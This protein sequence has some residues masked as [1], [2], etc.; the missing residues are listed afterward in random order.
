MP[1]G[2]CHSNLKYRAL[3]R[4]FTS[5]SSGAAALKAVVAAVAVTLSV[6]A[7]VFTFWALTRVE[8]WLAERRYADAYQNEV[9]AEGGGG[10][11]LVDDGAA[12]PVA[13]TSVYDEGLEIVGDEHELAAQALSHAPS[14]APRRRPSTL[15]TPTT[16]PRV[17]FPPAVPYMIDNGSP[18]VRYFAITFDGGSIAN[19]AGEILD[20]LASRGVKSTMFLTGAFI[21][22]FPNVV[23][24]I[25]GEGHEL[26]N[27]TLTHPRLTTYADNMTQST[28]PGIS[29]QTIANELNGAARVLADRTG[30]R[31]APLWRAPYGEY[32]P[33]ICR[34]AVDAGYVH[35]G[36]RHGRTWAQNLDTNDWVPDESHAAYRT[37]GEVYDKIVNIASGPQG[38]NGGIIL[39]HL[40]TERKIRSEQAHIILGRLIDTLR[41][42]GYEPV[43]V[44]ELLYRSGIDVNTLAFG[45]RGTGAV[46]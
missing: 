42:M 22:R 17:S 1:D 29:Q 5:H 45:G 37:P 33:Q 12:S 41:G 34:W 11:A 14:Q 23:T 25:A 3:P 16:P 9:P 4:V 38:L 43:T 19:A 36:W 26:G 27:H 35:I 31:F 18:D 32:N 40:G 10:G 46:E 21:R 8:T 2:Q 24:R 15:T 39:M 44:S 20:T 7:A 13:E 28:R 6:C 30:L